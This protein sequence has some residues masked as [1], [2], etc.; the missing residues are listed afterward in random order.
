MKMK[1]P[2]SHEALRALVFRCYFLEDV[3]QSKCLY[4]LT[5]PLRLEIYGARS[6][7]CLCHLF[8]RSCVTRPA[9]F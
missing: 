2:I 7:Y 4:N 6:R 9:I 3:R 1:S 8:S 5:A